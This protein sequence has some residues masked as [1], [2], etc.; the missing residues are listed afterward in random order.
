SAAFSSAPS[1][2]STKNGL[3][4]VEMAK[5]MVC[6]ETGTAAANASS[7]TLSTTSNRMRFVMFAASL[8]PVQSLAT[9]DERQRM[10][11]STPTARRLALLPL[12]HPLHRHTP[13]AGVQEPI[14]QHGRQD[15]DAFG[16]VLVKRRHVEQV[17]DVA[18]D[19]DNQ[20]ADDGARHRAAAACEARAAENDG[21]D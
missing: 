18:Q 8:S 17:E 1:F 14:Q 5:P 13:A 15:D 9:S 4:S 7:S 12:T 16:H 3:F 10:P 2:R 20:R 19:A 6:A 21:R 11:N